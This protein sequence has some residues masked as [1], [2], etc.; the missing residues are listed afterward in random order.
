MQS[1]RNPTRRNRNIGT[2]KSGHGQDNELVIPVCYYWKDEKW[3]WSNL[4]SYQAAERIFPFA[5][6]I[7]FLVENV[8]AGYVHACTVDDIAQVL[9]HVPSDDLNGIDLIILRQPK[10]KEEI[11]NSAWGRL[12]FYA[13]VEKKKY[14][15][16]AIVIEAMKP[17]SSRR[18]SKS[19]TPDEVKELKRLADDG[20]EIKLTARHHVICSSLAATR[21]TQ[22]YRTLLH[23]IG[24]HVDEKRNPEAFARKGSN[25]KEVF[26]HSYADKLAAKLKKFG[27]IPFDRILSKESLRKDKLRLSDFDPVS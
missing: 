20:H 21:A 16:R 9:Q 10:R 11:L 27:V 17:V 22:L 5:N 23:E 24:H 18:W 7:T 6:R 3:F 26:A 15:G 14:E 13:E 4:K 19:L 2:A 1:G 8:I 25:E 12:V